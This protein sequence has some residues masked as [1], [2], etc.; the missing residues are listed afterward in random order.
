MVS[1]RHHL[2]APLR[3]LT[4]SRAR[5]SGLGQ[6]YIVYYYISVNRRVTFI[7][8]ETF[9]N[10]TSVNF[11]FEE[12]EFAVTSDEAKDFIRSMLVLDQQQRMSAAKA[13]YHPWMLTGL[14]ELSR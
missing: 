9:N 2:R 14:E 13:L 3:P 7:K 10:I 1:G 11:V 12:E 6:A 4:L 5:Q 8:Q